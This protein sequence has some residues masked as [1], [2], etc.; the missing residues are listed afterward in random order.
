MPQLVAF[1]RAINVGGRYI[2]MAALT[3]HFC[4][5]GFTDATTFIS[6]G[7][8]IFSSNSRNLNKLALQI[9]ADLEPLLGFK[10]EVFIRSASEVRQIAERGKSLLSEV[11]ADGDVNIAFF[12]LPLTE[13]QRSAIAALQ[14]ASETGADTFQCG[15]REVYWLTQSKQSDSKISN[16]VFER[17]LRARSTCRRASMLDRLS[18][19]LSSK[20]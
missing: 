3:E 14:S 10:S 7:N 13:E 11:P 6:S 15:D 12:A 20:S 18:K 5:L 16:A 8:V 9:E 4:S 2:K 19:L 17:K 1:L